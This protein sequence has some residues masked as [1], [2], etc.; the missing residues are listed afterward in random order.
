MQNRIT[1]TFGT[2]QVGGMHNFRKVNDEYGISLVGEARIPRREHIV[3]ERVIE[4]YER[5]ELN[6]SFEIRYTEDHVVK[7]NGI[8]YID[9]AEHNVI[10][11]MAIVSV[12]AY[13]ESYALSLVAEEKRIDDSDEEENKGVENMGKAEKI[14]EQ[15][16]EMTEEVVAVSEEAKPEENQTIAEETV[17]TVVSEEVVAEENAVAEET[18]AEETEDES[19]DEEVVD[20]TEDK[21]EDPEEAVAE[22][23][24][25]TSTAQSEADWAE[26]H[27]KIMALEAEIQNLIALKAAAD[28]EIE[29]LRAFEVEIHAIQAAREAEELARNQETARAFAQKQGLDV[30]EE[31]VA[32]AIQ[33][34]DYTAIAQMTMAK[35]PKTTESNVSVA[36]YAV[37]EPMKIKSRFENVL[38]RVSQ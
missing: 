19:K 34:L 2:T 16:I 3:C 25:E 12:P 29:R 11:G 9:V 31:A 18:V 10:T 13:E 4:L 35:E 38:K 33:S 36:G 20:E 21:E 7:D 8:L 32:A 15:Q 14:A 17:E 23:E 27:A 1:G 26:A 37:V 28:A 24:T 22:T 30:N 6:F 5:G